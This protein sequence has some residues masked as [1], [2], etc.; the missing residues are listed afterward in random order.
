MLNTTSEF[1]VI[2]RIN[3]Y[4]IFTAKNKDK[5]LTVLSLKIFFNYIFVRILD[6]QN[7]FTII[8]NLYTVL[9]TIF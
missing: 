1:R 5:Y 9:N 2:N 6:K 4:V 3:K 7:S 8:L